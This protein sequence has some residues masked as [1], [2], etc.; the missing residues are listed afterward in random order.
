M[1]NETLK[2][3]LAEIYRLYRLAEDRNRK[4]AEEYD[5]EAPGRSNPDREG[6]RESMA[7][8]DGIALA[9]SVAL[10]ISYEDFVDY[11]NSIDFELIERI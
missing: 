11:A 3:D 7:A 2:D 5:I 6:I 1:K 9:S 8:C 10:G 4:Y